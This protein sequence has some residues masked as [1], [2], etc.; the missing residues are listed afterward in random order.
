MGFRVGIDTGGTFT[1]L[2]AVDE[3]GNLFEAKSPTTPRDLKIGIM[4]CLDELAGT[5]NIERRKLLG[6][7]KVIIQGTT[8][9]TNAII[10]RS[11]PRIG[12]I[13]TKGHTD[14]IQ[15]RRVTKDNM[16]D[17]RM[18]YP[19]P[20]VPRHLRVGVEERLDSRGEVLRPLNEESVHKAV[21]FLKK[22]EVRSIVVTL[23]FSFLN[24]AHE[25]RVREII[26]EDYP[27]VH[28]T[29]SSEVAPIPGEYERFSTAVLDAY[30]RPSIA[31]Y[32]E[33]L[34]ARLAEEGFKGQLFFI[35]NN[36][37]AIAASEA[38]HKPSTLAMSGP[39]AAPS[40]AVAIGQLH[41]YKNLLSVDMGGTSFDIAIV[42]NGSVTVKNESVIC[43]HRFSLPIIDI[44]TL[45]AGGG[46][47]AWFDLGGTL[48]VGPQSA[49][50]DPGP[51]CYGA[52]GTEP[53][54]TDANVILGYI[55]PDYFLGG[56]M[57]LSKDLAEKAIKEKVAD[58]LGVSVPQAAYAIHKIS[59]SAMANGAAHAFIK[60]G[61][62]PREFVLIAG[63][64]ATSLSA[65]KIAEELG[66]ATVLIARV[67]P[68]YCPFGMLGVDIRHDFSR[69]YRVQG[70]LL[71]IEHLEGLY[72]AMEAE[73]T[74]MLDKEN[75]PESQRVLQRTL[76]MRYYGQFRDVEVSWPSGPIT[77]ETIAEGI[78]NFHRR[79]K[80]LFGTSN[81]NYPLEFMSFG[82]TAIGKMPKTTLKEIE[83]GAEDA[84]AA[85]KAERD[86]YFEETEGYTRA[87]IYDSER[88]R[89]GM[90]LEGPCIVEDK[91][92]TVVI[93]L[94]FSMRVDAFG[95]YVTA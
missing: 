54:V 45:G 2:I 93:P 36:G 65:L 28:V 6:E 40:A 89:A 38:M 21:A 7:I 88:L 73:G 31:E 53:T 78:E 19:Q 46:S 39:A 81:D 61:Y 52:G 55:N 64:A 79:H 83:R 23:L 49:G 27:A 5:F 57:K 67:A 11:G 42:D 17:W 9:G 66:I 35:Q 43:D 77:R 82:L 33:S 10:T 18:P 34:E 51:V 8:Q 29:L 84:S 13:G 85:L 41:D 16:W 4:N 50:A 70:N 91:M 32:I 12:I 37:G 15:L 22:M 25:K 3:Q 95:N 68:V 86:A 76:R 56:K 30:I 24:S 90:L 44:E 75:V 87:R 20:L 14:A 26:K 58:R 59:N 71:D 60:K 92:T 62:D 69:Y 47:L 80:E 72:K 1:D 74:A 94:N 48:R 63:G